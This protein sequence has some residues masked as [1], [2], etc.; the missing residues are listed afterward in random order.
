LQEQEV[1]SEGCL[2]VGA[3][4]HGA[5]QGYHRLQ[6]ERS[7]SA[8]PNQGSSEVSGLSCALGLHILVTY[9]VTLEQP[10]ST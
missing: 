6:E 7:G 10:A 1:V 2:E 3:R 9:M 8:C 5:H 4:D